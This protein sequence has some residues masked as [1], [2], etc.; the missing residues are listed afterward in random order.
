MEEVR[1][2]TKAAVFSRW[3]LGSGANELAWRKWKLL[4]LGLTCLRYLGIACIFLKSSRKTG[5]P[6]ALSAAAGMNLEA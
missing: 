6:P 3:R 1:Y 2:S 5:A 4:V